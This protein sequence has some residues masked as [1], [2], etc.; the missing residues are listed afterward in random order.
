[1]GNNQL[2][3]KAIEANRKDRIAELLCGIEACATYLEVHTQTTTKV[4]VEKKEEKAQ[5]IRQYTAE[6]K[7][8]LTV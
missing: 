1:V 7:T 4:V 2:D 5:K 6:L 8:L 3:T